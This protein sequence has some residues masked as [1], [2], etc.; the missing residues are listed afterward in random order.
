MTCSHN[1]KL[2]K[3]KNFS[4]AMPSLQSATSRNQ[5]QGSLT[6]S[7]RQQHARKYITY[8]PVG[9][10]SCQHNASIEHRKQISC[11]INKLTAGLRWGEEK[12]KTCAHRTEPSAI[13]QGVSC[14]CSRDAVS[15]MKLLGLH[16][17]ASD[18]IQTGIL[19]ACEARLW[20][21]AVWCS[22]Q[23]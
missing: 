22:V 12:I 2:S 18:K 17:V 6:E 20:R 14:S 10:D 5:V 23:K 15:W 11:A 7:R 13:M 3:V 19:L 16:L 9:R 1:Y 4:L 8:H 21:T